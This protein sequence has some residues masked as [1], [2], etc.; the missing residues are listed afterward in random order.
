M[1]RVLKAIIT[2]SAEQEWEKLSKDAETWWKAL[3]GKKLTSEQ[4]DAAINSLDYTSHSFGVCHLL[5]YKAQTE[6]KEH[7]K[8]VSQVAQLCRVGTAPQ[9]RLCATEFVGICREME[10]S[11][12]VMCDQRE[13]QSK[14]GT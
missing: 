13:T 6:M 1:E 3:R 8:F 10:K 7:A 9:L 12:Q 2:Y 14:T 11:T 4:F 5:F